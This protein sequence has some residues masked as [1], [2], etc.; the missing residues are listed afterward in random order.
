MESV[1]GPLKPY[2]AISVITVVQRSL[3]I[4]H[5]DTEN[6]SKMT[7]GVSLQVMYSLISSYLLD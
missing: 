3:D 4:A 1:R 5:L 6:E 7:S 2:P